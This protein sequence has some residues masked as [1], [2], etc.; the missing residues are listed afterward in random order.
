MRAVAVQADGALAV[1]DKPEPTPGPGEVLVQVERCGICG[2]D[3]H[4]RNSGF[5]P[6]GAVMGHEFAGTVI[7]GDLPAGTRVAVLPSGRDGTCEQCRAG[8]S[9]LCPAQAMTAI[10]LGLNDGAYAE[11]VRAP[12]RSC[13][14]VPDGM[15]FEQGA[16]V[17]PYAVALHAVRRSR[18]AAPNAN[19]GVIGAGPVGLLTIAALRHH[20]VERITVAERSETRAA[21]AAALG[22]NVQVTDDA[23]RL[24]RTA[25]DPFDVIFDAAGVTTTLPIALE[26]TTPGGQLVLVG[27]VDIGEMYAMPGML[28]VIKEVD[29]LP[30]IA[31]TDDEF[32]EAVDH[33]AGGAVPTET[34]V[35][36]IRPLDAAEASFQDLVRPGG[37]VKVLLS[38]R[39]S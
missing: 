30:S 14:P 19:V 10:G 37:P 7:A 24:L 18:A 12:A 33:V 20:G 4:L 22:P 27:V 31:Y 6:P 35:S 17:E 5:I 36:D 11:L 39:S 38:P 8:K 26:A 34:V 32:R 25:G 21:A 29:V 28:W 9:H 13:I 15:S 1:V 2:S 23:S 16:L 3:L